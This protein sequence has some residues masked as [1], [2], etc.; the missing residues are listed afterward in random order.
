MRDLRGAAGEQRLDGR[1]CLGIGADHD[2]ERALF[3]RLAGARDRRIGI[4][5]ALLRELRRQR[6]REIDRRCAEIDNDLPAVRMGDET[7][8]ART[9]GLD[10]LAAR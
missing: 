1:K 9:N 7:V 8:L 3:R 5:R 2:A 6:S 10:M 4:V